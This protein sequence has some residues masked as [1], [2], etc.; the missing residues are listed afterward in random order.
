MGSECIVQE[1]LSTLEYDV[2]RWSNLSRYLLEWVVKGCSKLKWQVAKG[3]CKLSCQ[4]LEQVIEE[5][6]NLS[7][8]VLSLRESGGQIKPAL[9]AALKLDGRRATLKPG[10]R[11][12]ES[13]LRNQ[14]PE[15]ETGIRNP[16]SGIRKPETGNYKSQKTSSSNLRKLFCIAFA[17]KNKR[18]WAGKAFVCIFL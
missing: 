2:Q 18:L 9:L 5:W 6:G 12:P 8:R 3:S 4:L 16:E 13:R 1:V 11:K 17:G 14:N 7:K 15:S 10:N